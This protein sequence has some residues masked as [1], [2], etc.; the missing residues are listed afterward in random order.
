MIKLKYN[1]N[2]IIKFALVG[3]IILLFYLF[4]SAEY[5]YTNF[6]FTKKV[7][8]YD[9]VYYKPCPYCSEKQG[10]VANVTEDKFLLLEYKYNNSFVFHKID[11]IPTDTYQVIGKASLYHKINLFFG[12]DIMSYIK[13]IIIVSIV[14]LFL[15]LMI[16]I[17]T[18]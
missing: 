4:I 9:I 13:I 10:I 17:T 3:F 6:D 5:R 7:E 12:F 16:N 2:K 18:L 15:S 8:K 11:L 1:V 14:L